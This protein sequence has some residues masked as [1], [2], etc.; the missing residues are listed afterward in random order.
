MAFHRFG[1][2]NRYHWYGFRRVGYPYFYRYHRVHRFGFYPYFYHRGCWRWVHT[3][4]GW[5]H[6]NVCY[7]WRSWY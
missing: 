1:G 5:R 6:V 2:F 3:W 7:R 4:Y